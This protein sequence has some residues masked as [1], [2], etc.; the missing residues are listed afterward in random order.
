MGPGVRR[1]DESLRGNDAGQARQRR[2]NRIVIAISRAD[3]ILVMFNDDSSARKTRSSTS[4]RLRLK[5]P[6][7]HGSTRFK[8]SQ[9]SPRRDNA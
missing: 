4:G 6:A 3:V 9:E 7:M 2:A 8:E 5:Q 1:D